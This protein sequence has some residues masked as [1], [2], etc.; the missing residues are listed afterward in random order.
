MLLDGFYNTFTVLTTLKS[1]DLGENIKD[2]IK[3]KLEKFVETLQIPW[4]KQL[5]L[6]CPLITT[7]FGSHTFH[8]LK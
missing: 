5:P 4:T 6:V 3:I 8:P 1:S 7:P 2:I